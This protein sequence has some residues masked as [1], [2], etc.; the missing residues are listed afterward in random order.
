MDGI[1][2]A[3]SARRCRRLFVGNRVSRTTAADSRVDGADYPDDHVADVDNI[4][5]MYACTYRHVE[6]NAQMTDTGY[7]LKDDDIGAMSKSSL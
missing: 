5:T 2:V 6:T 7:P 1:A 3:H 4:L